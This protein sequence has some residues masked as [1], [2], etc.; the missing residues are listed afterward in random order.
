MD[1]FKMNEF[2]EFILELPWNVIDE[3]QCF[4]M[5]FGKHYLEPIFWD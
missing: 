2:I 4:G 3:C 5:D 1:Q